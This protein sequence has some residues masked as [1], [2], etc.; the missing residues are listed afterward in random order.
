LVG[1]PWVSWYRALCENRFLV[2]TEFFLNQ[3]VFFFGAIV[4]EGLNIGNPA[5]HVGLRREGQDQERDTT[6]EEDGERPV[7]EGVRPVGPGSS[8]DD[9]EPRLWPSRIE[10]GSRR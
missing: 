5:A 7:V 8:D 2:G 4:W 1:L 9:R 10:V 3:P 6:V